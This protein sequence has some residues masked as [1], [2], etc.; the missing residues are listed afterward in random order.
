MFVNCSNSSLVTLAGLALG[1][2]GYYLFPVLRVL[3]RDPNEPFNLKFMIINTP[4]GNEIQAPGR[5]NLLNFFLELCNW[6][7]KKK[8]F[9][10]KGS[11][12]QLSRYTPK[13]P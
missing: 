11:T 6:L 3:G 1:G 7:T 13:T 8:L 4:S 5:S 12:L 10:A 9:C 2:R